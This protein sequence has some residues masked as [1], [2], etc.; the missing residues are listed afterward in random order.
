M[1]KNRTEKKRKQGGNV[2]LLG[3]LLLPLLVSGC[4]SHATRFSYFNMLDSEK[5]TP[6]NKKAA[7]KFWSSVRPVSTL[8]ASHYKLGRFYQQQ[9]KYDKAIEEF[10]KAVRD[11][12]S[13]CKA[14]NGIAMSYD[15]LKR[16]EMASESYEQ[17][18]QCAPREAYVKNNYACSSIRCGNYEKGLALLL[19]ASQLSKDHKR[20]KNNIKFAQ[21]L[22]EREHKLAQ[23]APQRAT[24]ALVAKT[25]DAPTENENGKSRTDPIDTKAIDSPPEATPGGDVTDN[26]GL[27]ESAEKT[28]TASPVPSHDLAAQTPPREKAKETVNPPWVDTRVVSKEAKLESKSAPQTMTVALVAKTDDA[29]AENE[30]VKS[31][32]DPFDAKAIES[33]PEATPG[34]DVAD[35]RGPAES[36]EKTST[37]SPVPAHDLA[38]LTPPWEKAAETVSPPWADTGVVSKE[39]GNEQESSSQNNIDIASLIIEKAKKIS[40]QGHTEPAISYSNSA[41]EVSNGNGVTGMAGRSAD[42]FRSHGFTVGRITNAE[43]FH[44]HHSTVFYREGY[45]RVAEELA[46]ITP[47]VQAI[48]KVDS[49]GR[50]SIGVRIL[51]GK[52]LANIE[53]PEGYAQNVAY[54]RSEAADYIC[55]ISYMTK[56]PV[57]Y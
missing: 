33:P 28:S 5:G 26:R 51:L 32:T 56:I 46:R 36:A 2:N 37:A 47:G 27:A 53:F 12:S 24:V 7:E 39:S 41:I 16:C 52:D 30:N 54:S 57:N 15:A 48:E 11:D 17:A 19:E 29:P 50:S 38:A 23:S 18:M 8:S 31:L 35:N 4:T 25:D 55:S 22:V 34:E 44:F 49:L 42:F 45:L 1:K 3:L 14:Y 21:M 20:I 10:S 43:Y 40:V 13:Y 6:Q 9:G